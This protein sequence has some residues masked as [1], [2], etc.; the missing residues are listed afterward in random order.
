MIVPQ[1]VDVLHRVQELRCELDLPMH[2]IVGMCRVRNTFSKVPVVA[3]TGEK[4]LDKAV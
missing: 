3:A 2:E 1:V 4:E